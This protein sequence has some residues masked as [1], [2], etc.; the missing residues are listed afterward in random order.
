[1]LTG[2]CGDGTVILRNGET[3]KTF[4]INRALFR[5]YSARYREL[6]AIDPSYVI[7]L[8]GLQEESVENW[9]KAC[10]YQ[11]YD[12]TRQTVAE[13]LVLSKSWETPAI[14]KYLKSWSAQHMDIAVVPIL[15]NSAKFGQD[16]LPYERYLREHLI[17]FLDDVDLDRIPIPILDRILS[18]SSWSPEDSLKIFVAL[19]ELLDKVGPEAS[20]LFANFDFSYDKTL[21]DRLAGNGNYRPELV[22][23]RTGERLF[24]E[25]E[26]FEQ[27]KYRFLEL[28]ARKSAA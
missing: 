14:E 4:P 18:R 9:I 20:I 28:R 15:S 10:Q 26:E 24:T 13:I 8:E 17:A 27:M 23:E 16:A 3:S 21:K 22:R 6:S 1:M 5:Q 19:I 7:E 11:G 12:F 25:K 2:A